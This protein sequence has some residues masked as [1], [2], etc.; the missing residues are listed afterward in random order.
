MTLQKIVSGAQTGVD[1]AALDVAMA[2]GVPCGGWVPR[3]RIDEHGRIPDRYPNLAE[4]ES[5][6]FN[7]RTT[8]NVRDSTGTLIVSRGSL[9]GG[10]L[11]TQ[12]AAIEMGRPYLHLDLTAMTRDESAT[13]LNEWLGAKNIEVL[14][15]AGPRESK[16][17]NLYPQVVTLLREVLSS[18]AR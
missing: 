8:A 12:Q 9:T 13:S 10:S 1:R 2:L 18:R 6:D 11:F 14:N 16:D 4:T 17:P 3:G 5:T 15:V 7:E